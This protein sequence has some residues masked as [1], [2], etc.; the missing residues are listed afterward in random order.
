MARSLTT[1]A[2]IRG[3]CVTQP[4]CVQHRDLASARHLACGQSIYNSR[5][6]SWLNRTAGAMGRVEAKPDKSCRG[7]PAKVDVRV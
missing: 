1:Q 3:Y 5:L 4:K 2:P 7:D 6:Y